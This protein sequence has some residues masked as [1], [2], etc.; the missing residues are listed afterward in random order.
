MKKAGV[1]LPAGA[2]PASRRRRFDAHRARRGPRTHAPQ[3][4]GPALTWTSPR[5]ASLIADAIDRAATPA[6]VIEVGRADGPIWHEPFGRLTYDAD[7]PPTGLDTIFDLASLTKVIATTS[8]VMR[9]IA[10]GRLTLDSSVGSILDGWSDV[11]RAEIRVRHLLDHSSGFPAQRGCGSPPAGG[12][13]TSRASCRA[14]RTATRRGVG[15]LGPRFHGA[16]IRGRSRA[17]ARRST[18]S[19]RS[20]AGRGTGR[21]PS[22][23]HP[24]SSRVSLRRST[25]RGEIA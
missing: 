14:V 2:P 12:P 10:E 3:A 23:L 9:G 4:P 24:R 20:F 18:S 21:P 1:T 22:G 8:L 5:R 7:A 17:R 16:R 6:A 13:P 19:S 11:E 15:V 25:T